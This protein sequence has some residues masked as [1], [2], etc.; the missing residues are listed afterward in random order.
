[1]NILGMVVV[2]VFEISFDFVSGLVF[3]LEHVAGDDEDDY[4][5]MIAAHLL[6]I[7][8]VLLKNK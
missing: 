6:L 4:E 3:G 5:Y 1:V 7:R 8:I 2:V